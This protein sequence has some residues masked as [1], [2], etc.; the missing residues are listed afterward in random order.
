MR[1]FVDPRLAPSV[2]S[3]TLSVAT[4]QAL[5]EPLFDRRG[6]LV[7]LFVAVLVAATIARSIG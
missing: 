3:G 4:G 5:R 1:A 7:T 2:A 6:R